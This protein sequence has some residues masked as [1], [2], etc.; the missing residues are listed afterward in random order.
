MKILKFILSV[1][2][3]NPFLLVI[4][5]LGFLLRI[6]GTNPGYYFHGYEVMYS[7]AVMMIINHTIGL[8][9]NNLAYPPLIPW[10]MAVCFIFFFIPF[11][12]INYFIQHLNNMFIWLYVFTNFNQFFLKEILGPRYWQNAMIWGRDITVVLGTGSIILA[13]IAALEFFSKKNLALIMAL[14]MAV[15]YRLVLNSHLGFH[16]MFNVFFMFLTLVAIS[17]LLKKPNRHFYIFSFISAS[18][19]FL[20]KYQP[21]GFIAVGVT[22]LIISVKKSEGNLKLFVKNLLSKDV[23]IAGL[24]ALAII[25]LAHADYFMRYQE[26]LDYSRYIWQ[27]NQAGWYQL[28]LFPFSYIYYTGLGQILTII[29][30]IGVM[31]GLT[32]R[33]FLPPTLVLLSIIVA[34]FFL[35]AVFSEG[36]YFT[37][38]LLI[39]ISVSLFFAALF[40]EYIWEQL[41]S[42]LRRRVPKLLIMGLYG[43]VLVFILKDQLINSF[44]STSILAQTSYVYTAQD[45]IDKNIDGPITFGVYSSNPMPKKDVIK[46][47]YLP[48]LEEVFGF[49]EYLQERIDY[50]LIDLYQIHAKIFWWM[51]GPPRSPIQF[52]NRP[53]N[54]ISQDYLVLATREMLWNNTVQAFLPKWQAAGHSYAVIEIKPIKEFAKTRILKKFNFDTKNQW[55]SLSFLS[56]DGNKLDWTEQGRNGGAIIIK[57]SRKAKEH[58]FKT[59]PGS[60]RWESPELKIKSGFGYKVTGWIKSKN[61]IE[62]KFRN[63]FLRLDFYDKYTE[64]SIESRPMMTFLS[65]RIY[66][67]S[68]WIKIDVQ[69]IAPE[70]AGFMR[71]GFQADNPTDTFYLDDVEIRETMDKQTMKDIKH[72]ILSDEDFFNRSDSSFF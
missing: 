43:L 16:D 39:I 60:V 10:I 47:I 54:L 32:N 28:Y 71:V 56:R 57:S 33:K 40:F 6:I 20:I 72:Y 4:V 5:I 64:S 67:K 37:Y 21:S 2:G 25:F 63:G 34:T 38:N 44:I 69:A 41:S 23:I 24:V 42:R 19:M 35:F 29:S 1:I 51:V 12:F 8:E 61:D 3:K 26:W 11:A 13:Y 55:L 18:L 31:I 17:L 14:M 30:L 46:V 68:E 70:K 66:G 59:I 49:E 65:P 27:V 48:A 52:W 36:G 7:Q 62:K 53:D 22:H 15:N 45:W 50:V 9:H 58:V